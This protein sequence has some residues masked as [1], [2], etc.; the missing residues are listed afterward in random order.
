MFSD[1]FFQ[2]AELD[3]FGEWTDEAAERHRRDTQ[4]DFGHVKLR[5]PIDLET[6]CQSKGQILELDQTELDPAELARAATQIA[7][8]DAQQ[9]TKDDFLTNEFKS[10]FPSN[11]LFN[12]RLFENTEDFDEQVR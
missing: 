4:E 8:E 2:D 6:L 1:Y 10:S 9:T 3:E 11:E 7:M 5:K 12:Q